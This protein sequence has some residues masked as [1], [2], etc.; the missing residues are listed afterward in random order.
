M[1]WALVRVTQPAEEP[2]TLVEAKTHLRVDATDEDAL[3]SSLIASAREHVE[4]FQLRALVTQTW[5]LSLDRFPRGRVIRLPR[6]PLQSVTSITYTDPGGAQQTLSNT[7]YD[8]DT[9]SEPGR[10]VLKD[11][12]DWPDTADVPRAV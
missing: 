7:L 10:I 9:D 11:D 4:A 6:P 2:V 1:T 12:A 8:V 3:I 5:R